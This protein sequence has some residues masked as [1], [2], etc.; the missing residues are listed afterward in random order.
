MISRKSICL[1]PFFSDKKRFFVDPV[2][3]DLVDNGIPPVTEEKVDDF[4]DFLRLDHAVWFQ[5]RTGNFDHIGI[6]AAGTDGM[7]PDIVG[8]KL[9]GDTLCPSKQC[10]FG[11]RIN[12]LQRVARMAD[13]RSD[14]DDAGT[15]GLF[16]I[17]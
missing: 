5:I 8:I 2:D 4:G 11:G 9:P 15:W 10:V 1:S 13:H 7:H 3:E 6:N 14:I 17:R 12:A 16:Q